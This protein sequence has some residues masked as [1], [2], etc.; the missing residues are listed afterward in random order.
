MEHILLIGTYVN[1]STISN[2]S[3]HRMNMAFAS[4]IQSRSDVPVRCY[5]IFR[6]SRVSNMDDKSSKEVLWESPG[7]YGMR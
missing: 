1:K 3:K 4:E 7:Y 6:I 5:N 2:T